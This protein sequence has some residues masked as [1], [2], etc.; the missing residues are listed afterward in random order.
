MDSWVLPG[1]LCSVWQLCLQVFPPTCLFYTVTRN[2]SITNLIVLVLSF[3]SFMGFLKP[4]GL[5]NQNSLIWKITFRDVASCYQFL[6][7]SFDSFPHVNQSHFSEC[8][9]Y[10]TEH[11]MFFSQAYFSLLPGA[12]TTG[13][14]KLPAV[15]LENFWFFFPSPS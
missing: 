14:W 11:M 4:S 15:P 10:A 7:W 5:K 6:T 1:L 3:K 13:H 8:C 2:I 9:F 12:S